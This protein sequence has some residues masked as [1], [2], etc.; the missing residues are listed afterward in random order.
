MTISRREF[1]KLMGG[2]AAIYAFPGVFIHG[3]QKMIEKA[4]AR[5]NV[6][7]LQGQ[8]CSGCSVSLLNT[9]KPGI[10]SVITEHISLNFHQT[11]MGGTGDVAVSVL[12]DAAAKQRKDFV[13]ILEGSIPTKAAEY[14]TV[15]VVK[16][17][18]IGIAEWTRKLGANAKAVVAVGTCATYGGIPAAKDRVTKDNPTGAVGLAEYLKDIRA[19]VVNVPGCPPHPNWMIG[20]LLHVLLSGV[21]E[22]D[23]YRRPTM[24]FGKTVH[25]NCERLEDYKR[26]VY[27]KRWGDPGCLYNLGCLGMDSGCDIPVRKW[28]GGVN[29]CTNCGA[30]CI[31][32][33]EP[34][35]P[36]YG[37][38]GIFTHT[39]ASNAE[40]DAIEHPEVRE[41]VLKLKNGGMIH[42]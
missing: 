24:Y 27:A 10:A 39:L 17:K 20:T 32:C 3:C 22:L 30:G 18:H 7:W 12:A 13:L 2:A 42:G 36:D 1:L 35:F 4:A 6:I 16:G 41:A 19:D 28:L 38:R 25:E 37:K 5:T 33:T 14:C 29:T 8:S 11:V 34:V 40:I 31:G 26:G 21:P 15:G 9:A 23:E